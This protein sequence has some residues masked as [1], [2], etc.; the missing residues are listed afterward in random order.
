VADQLLVAIAEDVAAGRVHI[1][2]AE[3]LVQEGDPVQGL[4]DQPGKGPDAQ[5]L[6]V[7]ALGGRF[8]ATPVGRNSHHPAIPS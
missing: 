5:T 4:L 6:R 3:L 8:R 2:E 1:D 7:Q